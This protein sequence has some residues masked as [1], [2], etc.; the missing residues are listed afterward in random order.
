MGVLLCGVLQQCTTDPSAIAGIK[1]VTVS[2]TVVNLLRHETFAL[3]VVVMDLEDDTLTGQIVSWRSSNSGVASV[4]SDNVIHAGSTFGSAQL[5]ADVGNQTAGVTVTVGGVPQGMAIA[6]VD[7][8]ITPVGSIQYRITIQD[9]SGDPIP[10]SLAT[11]TVAT[12]PGVVQQT[13]PLG[14]RAIGAIGEVEVFASYRTVGAIAALHVGDTISTGTLLA[15]GDPGSVAVSSHRVVFV[16]RINAVFLSRMNLPFHGFAASPRV[17]GGLTAVVFDSGGDHAFAVGTGR[18]FVTVIDVALNAVVDSLPIGVPSP[19]SLI[20]DADD[21][22]LWVGASDGLHRVDRVSRT[23]GSPIPLPDAAGPLLGNPVKDS[24]LYVGQGTGRV[25]EVNTKRDSVTRTFQISGT[26]G[27][28]S[29][30]PDGSELY[31][32]DPGTQRLWAVDMATGVATDSVDLVGPPGRLA[33]APGSLELW[34]TI[35]S[36]GLIAVFD[37]GSR[38]VTRTLTI[39]GHP[40]GV[41]FDPAAPYALVANDPGNDSGFVN[42]IH[43]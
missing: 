29:M 13:G 36:Q 14:L 24:L 4:T 16:P 9:T 37:R 1:S 38:M 6:P 17:P 15:L 21:H 2:P 34:I 10:G 43:R 23:T 28:L 22:T 25:A 26:V 3:H 30:A 33:L 35:P 20:L 42:V 8:T 11:L 39:G 31:V 19:G 41:G 7:T 12:L 32:A 27:S 40:L 18:P 5:T